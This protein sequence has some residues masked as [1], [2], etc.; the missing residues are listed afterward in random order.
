MTDAQLGETAFINFD[1]GYLDTHSGEFFTVEEFHIFVKDLAFARDKSISGCSGRNSSLAKKE[2]DKFGFIPATS[3]FKHRNNNKRMMELLPI[4]QKLFEQI[5]SFYNFS[6]SNGIMGNSSAARK[7]IGKNYIQTISRLVSKDWMKE[8]LVP[9][10]YSCESNTGRFYMI[11]P[12]FITCRDVWSLSR[13]EHFYQCFENGRFTDYIEVESLEYMH[14]LQKDV[15]IDTS[16][17]GSPVTMNS[18]L[19]DQYMQDLLQSTVLCH[20]PKISE[21]GPVLSS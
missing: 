20:Q 18:D 3:K 5:N 17:I 13:S 16:I 8:V 11:N 14:M 2:Y 1:G 19:D 4:S 12:D 6:D 15:A 21:W 10:G 9:K 7:K